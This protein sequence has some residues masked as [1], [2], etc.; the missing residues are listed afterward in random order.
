MV[1]V[2]AGP[3]A[4]AFCATVVFSLTATACFDPHSLWEAEA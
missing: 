2:T 3:G 1:E 4:V